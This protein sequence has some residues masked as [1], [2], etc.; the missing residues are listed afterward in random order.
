MKLEQVITITNIDSIDKI[1][2]VMLSE[3]KG[4]VCI[5][6]FLNLIKQ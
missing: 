5:N 1:L 3:A 6:K 4:I 2:T